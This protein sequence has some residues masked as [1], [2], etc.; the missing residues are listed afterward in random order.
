MTSPLFTS[1]TTQRGALALQL[2]VGQRLHLAV[3]GEI[4]VLARLAG[5]LAQLADDAAIGVDLDA[6][7]AGLAAHFAVELLFD[8]ALADAQARQ[9]HQRIVVMLHVLRRHRGDIAQDMHQL[10]AEGIVAGLADIG[11]HARQIGQMQVDAGEFLPG[12]ILRHRHRHELLVHGDVVQHALLL[13]VAEQDHL[14]D[15]VQRRLDALGGLF[16]DQQHAIVAPVVGELDAEAVHDAAARRRDQAL[17]DA[18]VLGLDLVLVAVA[19]LQLI[20]AARQ[21]REHRRHATAHPHR[22]AGEGGVAALVLLVEQRHQMSPRD[23]PT[24]L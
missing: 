17:G 19:D 24:S 9:A 5:I 11:L 3:Q 1:I 13:L 14:A 7:G 12:E 16:G 15:R 22:A 20:E 2:L 21:H 4:D 10:L 6:A 8:A 23:A 18:V